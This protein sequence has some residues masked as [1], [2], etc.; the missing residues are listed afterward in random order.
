MA[1]KKLAH[2]PKEPLSQEDQERLKN[3]PHESLKRLADAKGDGTDWYNVCYRLLNGAYVAPLFYTKDVVQ[4]FQEAFALMEALYDR[5]KAIPYGQWAIS[6][7]EHFTVLNAI[8]LVDQITAEV[9]RQTQIHAHRKTFARMMYY[10]KRH[11]KFM[12]E[13]HKQQSQSQ[14]QAVEA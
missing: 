1:R 10:K 7:D 13:L 14:M 3:P 5:Q 8:E 4:L 11:D 6:P 2:L 9:D 12:A